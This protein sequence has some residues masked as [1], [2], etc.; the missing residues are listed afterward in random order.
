M[1]IPRRY[2]SKAAAVVMCSG[3][4][5]GPNNSSQGLWCV[6]GDFLDN[7]FQSRGF[8]SALDR[9]GSGF[10]PRVCGVSYVISCH[11]TVSVTR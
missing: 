6:L 11:L 4:K 1:E 8:R 9:I 3:R 7:E 5:S 10:R 2:L